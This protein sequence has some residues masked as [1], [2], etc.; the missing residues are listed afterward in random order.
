MQIFQKGFNYSQDGPGNRLVYHLTGCNM[1]CPWCS[2]PECMETG[3]E[4]LSPEEIYSE[5]LSCRALFFDGEILSADVPEKF[6]SENNF[7]TT[8]ANRIARQLCR[9]AVT[10]EQVVAFCEGHR[11]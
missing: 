6:F 10:C 11:R 9:N 5:A 8:A 7:Y 2:N 1:R 3:G 4:N